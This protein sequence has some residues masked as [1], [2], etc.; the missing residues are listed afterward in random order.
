MYLIHRVDECLSIVVN[1]TPNHLNLI[2]I[3]ENLCDESG[4]LICGE[5]TTDQLFPGRQ[6]AV[7]QTAVKSTNA[8]I[9]E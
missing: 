1:E 2:V 7:R 8:S 6:F 9:L 5:S 3:R 4:V